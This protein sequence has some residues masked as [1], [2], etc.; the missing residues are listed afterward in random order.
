MRTRRRVQSSMW[1]APRTTPPQPCSHTTPGNGPPPSGRT[2][3]MLIS[4]AGCPGEDGARTVSPA[5]HAATKT[6]S[7]KYTPPRIV[8]HIQGLDYEIL[9]CPEFLRA[10]HVRAFGGV[11][12][13]A[14]ALVDE[15]RDLHG[16][17]GLHLGGL[18][19]VGGGGVLD[20]GL[21]ID[22][23]EHHRRRDFH[24]DGAAVVEVDLDVGVGQEVTGLAFEEVRLQRELLVVLLVHEHVALAVLVEVLH[25]AR[26]YERALDLVLGAEAL[27]GLGALV[28]VLHLD[29]HEGAT[30]VADVD[31]VGLEHAPDALVPLEKIAGTDLDC[32]NL[33]H[34]YAP[35]REKGA[36]F[37]RFIM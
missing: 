11:D 31:V 30:A 3:R 22:H 37:T 28:D 26:I 5:A 12:L 7:T 18:E 24:A 2:I 16:D 34:G 23:R 13:N 25:F 4:E 29:L 6:A 36:N 21:G 8:G 35:A 17:A 15:G 33:G 19:G 9:V 32:F 1:R 10:L 20:A 27:V 14:L